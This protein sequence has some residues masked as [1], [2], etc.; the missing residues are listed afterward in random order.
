MWK[1]KRMKT[2]TRLGYEV[3]CVSSR[4]EDETFFV[5]LRRVKWNLSLTCQWVDTRQLFNFFSP[6]EKNQKMFREIVRWNNVPCIKSS[7]LN[8]CG[9]RDCDTMKSWKISFSL[10]SGRCIEW[11]CCNGFEM[12]KHESWF[13][14]P[15][16]DFYTLVRWAGETNVEVLHLEF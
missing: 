6:S 10:F 12:P 2:Y 8:G 13:F 3:C 16:M 1:M 15:S 4:N 9:G 7:H 14:M 11:K 5:S